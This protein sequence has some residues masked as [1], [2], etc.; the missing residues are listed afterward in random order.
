[1]AG[2][3]C[4]LATNLAEQEEYEK[5][6]TKCNQAHEI[7]EKTYAENSPEFAKYYYV[8]YDICYRK[9]DIDLAITHLEKAVALCETI[10]KKPADLRKM[11]T[12]LISLYK[13]KRSYEKAISVCKKAIHLEEKS[14]ETKP[15]KLLNWY[16]KVAE[17]YYL[18]GE[19]NN[20]ELCYEK[21]KR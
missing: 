13:G 10:K 16:N 3:Y 4:S 15:A 11:Y 18:E 2:L 14:F 17:L 8:L 9:N 5:A 12:R 21:L 7:L 1:M 6:L 19:Y 20:A